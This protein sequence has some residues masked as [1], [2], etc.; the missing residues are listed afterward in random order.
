M[1]GLF[2]PNRIA[3]Y[4]TSVLALI[5]GITAILGDLDWTS[6]V[7]MLG[8][9]AL[10]LGVVIKWLDGWQK[11]ESRVSGVAIPVNAVLALEPDITGVPVTAAAVVTPEGLMVET[12][13]LAP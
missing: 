8:S 10:I 7:G 6:I 3:V 12:P 5:V 13:P 1:A 4:L 11:H 2:A 9:V